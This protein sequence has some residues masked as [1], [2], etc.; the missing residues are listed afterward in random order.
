MTLIYTRRHMDQLVSEI[1][2]EWAPGDPDMRRVADA[3]PLDVLEA[4]YIAKLDA[5]P[6]E[7][8]PWIARTAREKLQVMRRIFAAWARTQRRPTFGQF[9]DLCFDGRELLDFDNAALV[10]RLETVLSS[11]N[12]E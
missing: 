2:N 12:G 9:I 5:F 6:P 1:R 7:P 11:Q 10:K 4:A 8:V 3:I